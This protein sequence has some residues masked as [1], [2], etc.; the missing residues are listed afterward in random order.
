MATCRTKKVYHPVGR[1]I[2]PITIRGLT[3]ENRGLKEQLV[4]L[5]RR[6]DKTDKLINEYRA[7]CVKKLKVANCH[8]C[9]QKDCPWMVLYDAINGIRK[10]IG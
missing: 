7:L 3:E 9:T 5:Y 8:V 4:N 10:L 6:I 2:T 1:V